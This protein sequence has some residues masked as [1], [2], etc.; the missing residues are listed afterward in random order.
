MGLYVVKITLV[1]DFMTRGIGDEDGESVSPWV[2]EGGFKIGDPH[3]PKIGEPI[4]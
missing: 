3:G 2:Y 4:I 1:F